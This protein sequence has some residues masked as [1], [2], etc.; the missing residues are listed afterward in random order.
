MEI[1]NKHII[2][3]IVMLL[4]AEPALILG[5]KIKNIE[6]TEVVL[7]TDSKTIKSFIFQIFNCMGAKTL[8]YFH[9]VSFCWINYLCH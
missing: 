8:H 2:A 3:E 1:V 4:K 5:F 7:T 6:D 9:K